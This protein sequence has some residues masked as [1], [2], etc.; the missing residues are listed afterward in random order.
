MRIRDLSIRIKL[1]GIQLITVIIVLVI[2]SLALISSGVKGLKK[3]R[4]AT[5]SSL[6][7]VVAYNC[8][9]PLDFMDEKGG[10]EVLASLREE[11]SVTNAVIFNEEDSLFA[12]YTADSAP[13]FSFSG[14]QHIDE[15]THAFFDDHLLISRP[16]MTDNKKLGTLLIRTDLRELKATNRE[17]AKMVL[18]VLFV[19]VLFASLI[20]LLFQRSISTP[21]ATLVNKINII[22]R[23]GSY[24]TQTQLNRK[25]EL[26][27]L[28]E[29]FDE[30]L[31][32]IRKKEEQL[33]R[34]NE[35]LESKVDDPYSRT[36][37]S[38]CKVE[39]TGRR[40]AG[41]YVCDLP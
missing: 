22:T 19:S 26:G 6:C 9:A 1:I 14:P 27:V 20:A 31:E 23:T 38:L 2:G 40:T 41:S 37:G 11:S 17:Y 21:I 29:E 33:N 4:L 7:E 15:G 39:R 30:M 35:D 3:S 10:A 28:S 36:S 25:D 8:I 24:D 32:V 16:I 13:E 5:L 18:L 34:L 12:A